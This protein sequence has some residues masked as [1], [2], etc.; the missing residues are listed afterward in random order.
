V[1]RERTQIK[2]GIDI[3]I[4]AEPVAKRHG[5]TSNIRMIRLNDP[6][7]NATS[8]S[9]CKARKTCRRSSGPWWII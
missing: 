8:I 9:A 7:A 1:H 6:R 3:G 2:L 4:V 5:K